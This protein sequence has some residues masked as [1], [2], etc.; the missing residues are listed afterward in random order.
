MHTSMG[1][2]PMHGAFCEGPMSE[3][4]SPGPTQGR[5]VLHTLLQKQVLGIPKNED[6]YSKKEDAYSI[7]VRKRIC[8]FDFGPKMTMHRPSPQKYVLRG[9]YT[10]N[11]NICFSIL[12]YVATCGGSTAASPLLESHAKCT[13][14]SSAGW[15]TRKP[16]SA[17]CRSPGFFKLPTTRL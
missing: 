5:H 11:A 4:S 3:A 2:T 8:I 12:N 13:I 9:P 6:A 1:P 7:L 15:P 14:V 10:Q 16:S 17:T